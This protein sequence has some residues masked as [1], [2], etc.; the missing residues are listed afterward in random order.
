[1]QK[2]GKSNP[3]ILT[4]KCWGKVWFQLSNTNK[5]ALYLEHLRVTYIAS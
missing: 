1:M 3:T 5:G 4:A 2:H